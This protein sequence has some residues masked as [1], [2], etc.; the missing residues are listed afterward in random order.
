MVHGWRN[1]YARKFLLERCETAQSE[2]DAVRNFFSVHAMYL[3]FCAHR[4]HIELLAAQSPS[5]QSPSSHSLSSFASS[6]TSGVATGPMP[7][8][9]NTAQFL[10][11]LLTAP[12]HAMQLNK[13]KTAIGGTRALYACVAKKLVR[14]D[15]GEAEQIVLFDV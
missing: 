9:I 2:R 6:F 8:Q 14:I 7:H 12:N 11:V 5:S 1:H 13:L 10:H 4:A 3:I 15:R